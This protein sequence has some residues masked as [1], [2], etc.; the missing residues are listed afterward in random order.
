MPK[1]FNKNCQKTQQN[2]KKNLNKSFQKL[3]VLE[4]STTYKLQT[5]VKKKKPVRTTN[6]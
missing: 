6:R 2:A 4:D 1:K 5:Y 3:K